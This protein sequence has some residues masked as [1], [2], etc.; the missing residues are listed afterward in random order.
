MQPPRSIYADLI[1]KES[2]HLTEISL[3]LQ[4]M[5]LDF[6]SKIDLMNT[7]FYCYILDFSRNHVYSSGWSTKLINHI[8]QLVSIF[9]PTCN[10]EPLKQAKGTRR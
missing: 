9:S 5:L 7:F 2:L 10:C 6:H 4:V 3:Q 1:L 8:E